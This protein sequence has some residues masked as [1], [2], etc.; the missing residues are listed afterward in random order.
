LTVLYKTTQPK[1]KRIRENTGKTVDGETGERLESPADLPSDEETR[2]L[3]VK[4]HEITSGV[5]HSAGQTNVVEMVLVF[6]RF[7]HAEPR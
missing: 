4:P 2:F 7:T 5:V 3:L 6:E 1:T